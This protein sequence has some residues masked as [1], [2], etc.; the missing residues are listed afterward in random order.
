MASRIA[1]Y[2]VPRK[3]YPILDEQGAK[4]FPEELERHL[5]GEATETGLVN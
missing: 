1:Y 2:R 3:Y 5:G 4:L